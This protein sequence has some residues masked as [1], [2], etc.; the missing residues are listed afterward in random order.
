MHDSSTVSE[1]DLNRTV[2]RSIVCDDNLTHNVRALEV[3]KR[4]PNAHS[5]RSRLIQARH[6]YAQF[7]GIGIIN[8]SSTCRHSDPHSK[9][10]AIRIDEVCGT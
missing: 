6:D 10:Q 3:S 1:S 8:K 7:T 4:F 9:P 5:Q 2:V